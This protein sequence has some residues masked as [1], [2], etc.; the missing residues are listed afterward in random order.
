MLLSKA[1]AATCCDAPQLNAKQLKLKLS[2]WIDEEL[3]W[4]VVAS[5]PARRHLFPW[6][7][8]IVIRWL[9]GLS[10]WQCSIS[11]LL[12]ET[13]HKCVHICGRCFYLKSSSGEAR[14][15]WQRR[16]WK[17]PALG[18][19]VGGPGPSVCLQSC[20]FTSET[21]HLNV[22]EGMGSVCGRYF[23]SY[24]KKETISEQTKFDQTHPVCYSPTSESQIIWIL[25]EIL[26]LSIISLSSFQSLLPHLLKCFW[27]AVKLKGNTP[28]HLSSHVCL[29]RSQ[30]VSSVSAKEHS[31][32][33]ILSRN[34]SHRYLLQCVLQPTNIN[35]YII[36]KRKKRGYIV[37]F[38]YC[39]YIQPT[40]R[41]HPQIKW[42]TTD[43]WCFLARVH[44]LVLWRFIEEP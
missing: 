20:P 34:N 37:F 31:A 40:L 13:P 42:I 32:F 38:I 23:C 22:L 29:C 17:S 2:I 11:W 7:Q 44:L 35:Q 8:Q 15:T 36:L 41:L 1:A 21:A 10:R 18:R 30:C 9:G 24:T 16:H 39:L 28:V 27:N 6:D 4:R 25:S 5:Y 3:Q 12:W 33:Y 14:K 19:S 26:H 43:C